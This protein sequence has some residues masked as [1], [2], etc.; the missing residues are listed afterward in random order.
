MP[1]HGESAI[2]LPG[3][4][5]PEKQLASWLFIKWLTE[6][7]QQAKWVEVSNYFPVRDSTIADLDGYIA[8]NPKYGDAFA[9]L[10]SAKLATEPPFAGYDEVRD[11]MA[12]AYNDILD[13]GDVDKI[14][15]DLE[16]EANQIYEEAS[17]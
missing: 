6:P 2:E 13:G 5:T 3:K 10:Q 4:T 9:I 12:A 7:K 11:A 8:E 1:R 16:V 14:L 15:T 17:P